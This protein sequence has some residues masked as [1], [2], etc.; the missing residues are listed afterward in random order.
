MASN[1]SS[2][3]NEITPWHRFCYSLPYSGNVLLMAPMSILQGIY[4]K[5]YGL[6]L[7]SIAIVILFSRIFD[8]VTDPLIGYISDQSRNK[9]GTRKHMVLIGGLLLCF[10]GY[11]LYV[12]PPEVTLNYFMIWSVLFYLGWTLFDIPHQSWGSEISYGANAKTT[13][14][15]YRGV[16]GYFGLIIFYTIPLLPFFDTSAITPQTLR[17]AFITAMFLLVPSLYICLRYVPNGGCTKVSRSDGRDN[18]IPTRSVL[19]ASIVGNRPFI[20]FLLGYTMYGLGFGMW[21]GLI[22]IYVDSYLGM[23]DQFAQMFLFAFV[24]GIAAVPVW[25]YFATIFGEKGIWILALIMIAG[26][27][28]CTGLLMPGNTTV[29][30][31]A[32]LKTMNTLGLACITI[33]APSMLSQIVDYGTWKFGEDRTATYFAFKAFMVKFLGAT[34]AAIGLAIAGWSGFD[35]GEKAHS[36]NAVL[37]IRTAISL[38]PLTCLFISLIVVCYFPI[39]RRRHSIVC[40]RLSARTA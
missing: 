31:L 25:R 11:F 24:I 20:L 19:L 6:S 17:L 34:G 5:Y 28:F 35:P 32:L 13:I 27:S 9:T 2:V 18:T 39:T 8:A 3:Q 14:F 37:G 40:R 22:Y 38:L 10:S 1:R 29:F 4:A 15:S 12:P 30:D 21:S 36:D 23:G 26:S 16:A 33:V 7:E